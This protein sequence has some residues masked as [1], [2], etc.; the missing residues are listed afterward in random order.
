[1]RGWL[2]EA[3]GGETIPRSVL[4]AEF[5]GT[6]YLLCALGDGHLFN[7]CAPGLRSRRCCM[8][9]AGTE[10]GQV[11]ALH[12]SVLPAYRDCGKLFTVQDTRVA[13]HAHLSSDPV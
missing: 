6:A 13:L 7:W 12:V 3:L 4:F 10:A 9:Q 1:M 2:Q 5:Q 11:A 8:V